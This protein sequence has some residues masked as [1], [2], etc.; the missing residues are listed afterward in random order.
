[1][2]QRNQAGKGSCIQQTFSECTVPGVLGAWGT[3]PRGP[4]ACR[5]GVPGLL[6]W[7]RG[8]RHTP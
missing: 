6:R 2:G 7:W 1:M 5:G 3:E 8:N 4:Y